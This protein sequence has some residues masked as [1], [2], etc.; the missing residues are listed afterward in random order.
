MEEPDNFTDTSSGGAAAQSGITYQ[1]R[2]AAWMCVRILAEQ[3]AEPPWKL[4]ADL[5]LEFLRCETDQPVDDILVGTSQGG[6]AFIQVKHTV[7]SIEGDDSA[8][9]SALSQFVRQY[10][11]SGEGT[12]GVRPWERPLDPRL[13]RLVLVTSSGSSKK[14]IERL[15]AVLTRIRGLPSGQNI[16]DA[17]TNAEERKVLDAARRHL[18]RAWSEAAPGGPTEDDVRRLFDLLWVQV[19]EVEEDGRDEREAKDRLRSSIVDDPAQSDA[20]WNALLRACGEYATKRSG[21]DRSALQRHLLTEVIRLKSPRSFRG[22]IERL[23]GQALSALRALRDLAVISLGYRDVKIRRQATRALRGAAELSSLV[24]VGDPGA[25][26]SGAIHDLVEDLVGEDRDV[27]LIAVDRLEAQSREG[28]RRELGLTSSIGEILRNWPGYSPGFLVIDALDA[29]RSEALARTLYDLVAEVTEDHTRW[30][31]VASIRKFDLR[32]NTK[33]R[34]LFSGRPPTGFQSPEFRDLCHFNV[35]PLDADEWAQI[36]RQAPELDQLFKTASESL[37]DLLSVPFNVRLLGDLLGGGSS[38]ESLWSIETQIG[39]LDR[40]WEERVIRSDFERDA[41]EALL[42]R[43]VE[44]MISARSLRINRREAVAA[45]PGL[46]RALNELLSSHVVSEW[47]RPSGAVEQSVLTFAHH[48][49]FDYAAARLLLRGEPHNLIGRL[50]RDPDLVLTIRPSI[51]MHFQHEHSRDVDA[52]WATV[53]RITK[54]ESIP[55]VGKTVGPAVAVE[56]AKDIEDFAP[57]VSALSS[58]DVRTRETAEKA[59]RHVT[60]ALLVEA[61]ASPQSLAGPSSV[62]WS[63]L[64]D[65]CA[66]PM[67]AAVV[68]SVSPVLNSMCLHPEELTD[69]QRHFAGRVARRLL[70]FALKHE[71]RHLLLIVHGIQAVCRTFESDPPASASVLRRCLEPD[72]VLQHGHEELFR[73]GN[74]ID[75]LIPLDPSLVEDIFKATFTLFDASQERVPI[76]DSRIVGLNTTPAQNFQMA[77]YVLAGKY[78][79]FLDQSPLHATGALIAAINAYAGEHYGWGLHG[80]QAEES[81]DFDGRVAYVK[82]DHSQSWDGDSAYRDDKRLQ[83]LDTF[84]QYLDE[85]SSDP[86]RQGERREILNLIVAQNRTAALWRRL[87]FSGAKAPQTLGLDLRPLAWATPILK[88]YDTAKPVG[89]YLSVVFPHLNRAER[90]RVERTILSVPNSADDERRGYEERARDQLLMCLNEG[91]LV[92]D[93]AKAILAR[94]KEAGE[95]PSGEPDFDS[96]EITSGRYT[97]EDYLA[98]QKV[99]VDEDQNR[100][101]RELAEPAKAFA[102]NHLNTSPTREEVEQILPSLR[103]LYAA[104]QAAEVEGVHE[105][106]ED[107][108][109]GDLAGACNSVVKFDGLTCES[110]DGAFVKRVLVEAADYPEPQP[111]PESERSFDKFPSWGS[112]AARVDA[113]HGVIRMA[114]HASCVDPEL[115]EVIRRLSADPVP[116]VRYQIASNLVSLYHT[117]PD[118][119]WE[120]LESF[121]RAD[122]SRGVLRVLLDVPLRRLAAHHPDRVTELVRAI[123]ERIREG[124]GA[125][126]VRK[127]CAS[128]LV[129][130]SLWQRHPGSGELVNRVAGDPTTYIYEANQIVFDLRGL[131]NLG[132]VEPPN[133]NQDA[134]RAGSF[135]LMERILRAAR[136]RIQSIEV[137]NSAT[138]SEPWSSEDQEEAGKLLGLVD[139]VCMQVYFASGAYTDGGADQNKVPMGVPERSRFLREAREILELASE[140]GYP[141]HIHHLLET[142]EY[143]VTFD[144]E[145]VFLLVGRVVRNGRRGGYQYE[146]LASDL[147]V[148]FVERFIAEFRHVLQESEECRRTLIE[149][150]DTFVDAGWANARRLTYRMEEIFR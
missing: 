81:F 5:T 34:R 2:V 70:D 104:L 52:F 14:V 66:E 13:D 9:A 25:G 100:R 84:Q 119:M 6:H 148:R 120:L 57:L 139:S 18:E 26:K 11:A 59:L 115:L 33:L 105:R 99:S 16:S 29:A 50:E 122:E 20:S 49:L 114:R 78:K 74:E 133:G 94:L 37:R 83:M 68:Y 128:V 71:V 43:A 75:R 137:K 90:E 77:R 132:P 31:V 56:A 82:T 67:R 87:L 45:A 36:A 118:L 138:P 98:R 39:L 131:L 134:V 58:Q 10:L 143:L 107:M 7:K 125:E 109:W 76:G 21:A 129:G 19:L 79:E 88:G 149:T 147:I 65:Q 150:L 121:S 92:T 123:F 117:A 141:S 127:R 91:A 135:R 126:E 41:R 28:L 47:E 102:S 93:A 96:G 112:P 44:A 54:S 61:S 48:V 8:F 140:I 103:A 32:H 17:A 108:A 111:H 146:S 113:A 40:Y 69:Q 101:I 63:E 145:G 110:D 85:V 116:A 136:D 55:E 97:D 38:V 3:E 24:V 95:D 80:G 15:P 42:T 22:D 64:L 106:Q 23:K 73:L 86:D 1:N 51:V 89:E 144:P 12:K 30:R 27:V 53:F 35:P 62:Q 46:S 142:L 72:R 130:L 4:P 60:G 124:E